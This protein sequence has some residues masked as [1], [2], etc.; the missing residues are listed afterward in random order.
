VIQRRAALGIVLAASTFALAACGFEAPDV[1]QHENSEVQGTS[2]TIGAVRVRA[3][4]ATPVET[5]ETAT[6][7]YVVVTFVN[8]AKTPDTLTSATSPLGPVTL[9]G[10]AASNGQL[11]LPPGVPVQVV[12]PALLTPGPTMTVGVKTSPPVGSYVPIT[13]TFTNAGTTATIQAPIVP[14][15]ES[16]GPNATLSG[17]PATP[18]PVSLGS[19]TSD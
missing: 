6:P 2:L 12:D 14:A 17:S 5:S 11:T 13:F 8:D 18:P 16:E 4:F 9:S 3:V 10:G 1:T 15:G 7:L 19:V